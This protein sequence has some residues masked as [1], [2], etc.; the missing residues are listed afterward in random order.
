MEK[1]SEK[2]FVLNKRPVFTII[3]YLYSIPVLTS[4]TAYIQYYL[5]STTNG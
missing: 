5:Y 2:S 4:H 3:Q 1:S